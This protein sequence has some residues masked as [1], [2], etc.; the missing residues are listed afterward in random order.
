[1]RCAR[2]TTLSQQMGKQKTLNDW[3][4]PVDALDGPVAQAHHHLRPHTERHGGRPH[5]PWAH[6][7]TAR[8]DHGPTWPSGCHTGPQRP[9]PHQR[10]FMAA[11]L[12]PHGGSDDHISAVQCIPPPPPPLRDIPSGRCFFTG[13][14]TVTRSSL[15]MLRRVVAFCRVGACVQP[16]CSGPHPLLSRRP[17]LSS[18]QTLEGS[19]HAL[20]STFYPL[21]MQLLHYNAHRGRSIWEALR[22]GAP[23]AVLGIAV[24][25]NLSAAEPPLLTQLGHMA[26]EAECYPHPLN[27]TS[28][29]ALTNTSSGAYLAYRGSLTDPACDEV[30]TWAVLTDPVAVTRA[31]LD[32]LKAA[33]L[34]RPTSAEPVTLGASGT[35]RPLQ[36]RNGR[37]VWSSAGDVRSCADEVRDPAQCER[38]GEDV[39]GAH[40]DHATDIIVY[41][42]MTL[43]LGVLVQFLLDR[44]PPSLRF[45]YTVVIFLLGFALEAWSHGDGSVARYSRVLC[46][47][48]CL[49]IVFPQ[50]LKIHGQ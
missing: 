38:I 42:F 50:L 12:E 2:A 46:M 14:W 22:S 39:E 44:L 10:A 33:P 23:D 41:I 28:L 32:R 40:E 6:A 1:M 29:S 34:H 25:A 37:E 48:E 45:P 4:C 30:V 19:E 35:F 17:C 11:G 26:A 27:T 8:R 31:T 49:V 15:R 16:S 47:H 36:A 3:L 13:P 7:S 20:F 43:A 5:G 9:L 24:L 21:E 18:A